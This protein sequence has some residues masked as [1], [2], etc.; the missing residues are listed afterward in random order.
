MQHEEEKAFTDAFISGDKNE[1]KQ[2]HLPDV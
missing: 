1:A 2:L